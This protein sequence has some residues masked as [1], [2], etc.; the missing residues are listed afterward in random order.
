MTRRPVRAA[1][2]VLL[3]LLL[4]SIAGCSAGGV[5]TGGNVPGSHVDV[6]TAAMRKLKKQAGIAT[7]PSAT[8]A[9]AAS[10]P[11]PD[12]TLPCLGG[13]PAVHLP[14]LRGPMV[15]NLFA[16]WCGPCRAELPYYQKLHEQGRGEVSVLGI[17]WLDTQ[18]GRALRLAEQTGVTYPLLADPAGKLRQ[19]WRIRGLPGLVFIDAHGRVRDVEFRSIDSYAQLEHLVARHLGVR[20]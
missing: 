3:G 2:A 5:R 6:D 18:P 13:G 7:C 15:I 19:P 9:P 1:V 11:L 17:D 20:L 8:A 14:G 16:Q 12:L 4:L 10:H